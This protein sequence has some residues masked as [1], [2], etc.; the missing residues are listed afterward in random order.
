MLSSN[1]KIYGCEVCIP[2]TVIMESGLPKLYVKT[3]KNGCI[4]SNNKPKCNSLMYLQAYFTRLY[5]ERKRQNTIAQQQL[6][7]EGKS[8]KES[9]RLRAQMSKLEH[10]NQTT[11]SSKNHYSP[12]PSKIKPETLGNLFEVDEDSMEQGLSNGNSVANLR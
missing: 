4:V 9:S 8:L 6:G 1:E 5:T 2:E 12:Q 10:T 11:G 3:D 7:V